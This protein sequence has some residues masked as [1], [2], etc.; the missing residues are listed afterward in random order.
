MNS[1]S[2]KERINRRIFL[3]SAAAAGAGLS[4]SPAVFG[5][6]SNSKEPDDINVALLGVGEQ[7]QVL[8]SACL[9]IP[10]IRIKAVCDIWTAYN[11]RRVSRML[12][13]YRHEHNAYVDYKEMLDKEKDLDAVIV[14]TPDFWH[15]PHT[16][17]CL[18]AGLN[19]YC[20]KEMSNSLEKAASMVKTAKATGKL[21]QIG[22][23]R[24]SNPRYLHAIE[25]LIHDEQLLGQ[26]TTA[27][28]LT[29]HKQTSVNSAKV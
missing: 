7:G 12:K 25:K 9:K 24:R 11:Q 19:V 29:R 28:A 20:E 8:M 6:T 10:G 21:L 27:T 18:E 26:I 4:F 16:V 5:R 2:A 14:A 13:A 22:H 23:Q 15:S 17:A 1:R 3:R